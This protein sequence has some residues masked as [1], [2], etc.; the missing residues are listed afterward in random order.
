MAAAQGVIT[1]RGERLT[2]DELVERLRASDEARGRISFEQGDLALA[3]VPWGAPGEAEQVK[4][5]AKAAGVSAEMLDQRR[6]V[7]FMVAPIHRSDR[8]AWSAYRELTLR[9]TDP[10]VR[11]EWLVKVKD[12]KPEPGASVSGRWTVSALRVAMGLRPIV[13]TSEPLSQR[14]ALASDQEKADAYEALSRDRK[15][16]DTVIQRA[17]EAAEAERAAELEGQETASMADHAARMKDWAERDVPHLYDVALSAWTTF[18][19]EYRPEDVAAAVAGS[20]LTRSVAGYVQGAEVV[21]DWFARFARGL[22]D[23]Q[24]PRLVQQEVGA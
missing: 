7:S 23:A 10:G 19:A 2:R 1:F 15:V 5:L 21:Q 20:P 11:L 3:A 6:E 14:L 8:V 13:H 16:R 18:A 24:R 9:V 17:L 22:R 12:T 4:A